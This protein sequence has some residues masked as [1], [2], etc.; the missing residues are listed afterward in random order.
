LGGKLR[1]LQLHRYA[2]LIQHLSASPQG[3]G[4]ADFMMPSFNA[5]AERYPLLRSYSEGAAIKARQ[6][7][8]IR[9]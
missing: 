6:E 9:W 1:T 4:M 2:A 3:S 5:L 8:W 7:V